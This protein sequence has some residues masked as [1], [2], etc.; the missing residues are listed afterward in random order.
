MNSQAVPRRSVTA[1]A[2]GGEARAVAHVLVPGVR[3]QK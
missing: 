1:L 2:R 3:V